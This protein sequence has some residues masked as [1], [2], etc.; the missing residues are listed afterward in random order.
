MKISTM[1]TIFF[2]ILTGA[3]FS[4]CGSNDDEKTGA[5]TKLNVSYSSSDTVSSFNDTPN[6]DADGGADT[7]TSEAELVCDGDTTNSATMNSSGIDKI[8]ATISTIRFFPTSG[9]HFNI[10]INKTFDLLALGS[11][12]AGPSSGITIPQNVYKEIRI[13][14][15]CAEFNFSDGEIEAF[16]ITADNSIKFYFQPPLDYNGVDEDEI[17][18][19]FDVS[20]GL[21]WNN[22]EGWKLNQAYVNVL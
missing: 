17:N 3:L 21:T 13:Y 8:A 15:S 7:G 14:F 10:D 20:G 5:S 16:K 2:L 19:F 18:I 9:G 11:G 12:G 4:G 22:D 6:G 1:P